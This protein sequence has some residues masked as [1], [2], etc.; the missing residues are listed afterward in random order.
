MPHRLI[1]VPL[2]GLLLSLAIA[3]GGSSKQDAA[4]ET[5]TPTLTA[6]TLTATPTATVPTPAQASVEYV[7][8][9]GDTLLAIAIQFDVTVEAIIAANDL[10][11]ADVL[12]IDQVLLIPAPQAP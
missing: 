9:A 4:R 8:V 2:A 6:E 3:C 12:A 7:V 5:A 10:A 1:L 11:D